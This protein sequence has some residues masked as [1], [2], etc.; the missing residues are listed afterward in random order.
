MTITPDFGQDRYE[1]ASATNENGFVLLGQ[2]FGMVLFL[3][4]SVTAYHSRISAVLGLLPHMLLAILAIFLL[5]LALQLH[6]E[7]LHGG[8]LRILMGIFYT[9][10]LITVAILL[11]TVW[12]M[13]PDDFERCMTGASVILCS[14]GVSAIAIF[15]WPDGR[16][17]GTI[18]PNA[19]SLPLLAA[20]IFSQFR[21][22]WLG[23]VIRILCLGMTGLVSSRFAFIGCI[24][25]FVMHES[26]LA[27]LSPRKIAITLFCLA[28]GGAFWPLV[29]SVLNNVLALDDPT[30]GTSSG[31]SGRSDL[32]ADSL[33][34]IA[35]HPLGIGFKRVSFFGAGGH[36]GYLK[37]LLEFG[38]PGGG[39]ILLFFTCVIISAGIEAV[40]NPER[41]SRLHRF[42]SA[43]FGGLAAL[44]FGAFFCPQLF[45]LGDIFGISLLFLMFKPGTTPLPQDVDVSGMIDRRIPS[46]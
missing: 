4:A 45:N 29:A 40:M 3:I 37:T 17:V 36:N 7:Q 25:A 11:S 44:S 13:S 2:L 12:T 22:G 5:S 30:R 15:G 1:Y 21:A 24:T 39:L 31:F 32:W 16:A 26:T 20:F 28:A 19:F 38:I 33:A 6:D 34:A 10:L 14:F 43:R 23:I 8:E 35:D 27:P 9:C 46:V 18:H 41:N 42:A